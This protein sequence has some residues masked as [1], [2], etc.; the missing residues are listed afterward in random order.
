MYVYGEHSVAVVLTQKDDKEGE[1]SIAFFSRTLREYESRY[2]FIEKQA[3]AMLKA[4][5]KFRHLVTRNKILILVAHPS[6]R[7][8]IMEGE[9][10]EKRANWI[11]KI[12]EY[13]VE[14]RPTKLVRGSELP[15][16]YSRYRKVDD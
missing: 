6:V 2:N 7:E 13:D 9:I 11:T 16:Y 15:I 5:K 14:V 3:Y 4:L 8:Y 10:T 1:H 12:L